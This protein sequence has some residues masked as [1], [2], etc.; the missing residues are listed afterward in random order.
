MSR[1]LDERCQLT[2]TNQVGPVHEHYCMKC[3]VRADDTLY[4]RKAGYLL[5]GTTTDDDETALEIRAVFCPNCY[6]DVL[7]LIR[8]YVPEIEV[9]QWM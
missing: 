9:L 7:T 4:S 3:G 1:V 8:A 2:V 5:L 6:Q